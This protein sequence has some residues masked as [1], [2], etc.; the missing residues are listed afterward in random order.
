MTNDRSEKIAAARARLAPL[1]GPLV[2]ATIAAKARD[3]FIGTRV[4]AGQFDIVRSVPRKDGNHEVTVIAPKLC[5]ADA[6]TWLYGFASGADRYSIT[7]N[8]D[9]TFIV[10]DYGVALH[11][12]P[13][14]D[15][16]ARRVASLARWSN[17]NQ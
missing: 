17:R 3:E 2:A 9:G 7:D 16:A 10:R 5:G 11:R 14:Y 4:K 6:V 15:I 1:G 8:A 12:W 13:S